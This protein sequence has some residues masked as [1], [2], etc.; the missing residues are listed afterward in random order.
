MEVPLID[1]QMILG[2]YKIISELNTISKNSIYRV[3]KEADESGEIKIMKALPYGTEEEVENFKQ[4]I[5]ILELFQNNPLFVRYEDQFEHIIDVESEEDDG[6]KYKYKKNYMFVIMKDYGQNLE[7]L[8]DRYRTGVEEKVVVEF[9]NQALNALK[10]LENESVVHHDIKLSNFLIASDDPWKFV[11]IDFEFAKKLSDGEKI[12]SR[13]GTPIF[14]A[15]EVL[16]EE[17]H[18]NSAD[19]WGIGVSAFRLATGVYPFKITH[20]DNNDSILEKI[21]NNNAIFLSSRFKNKS[22]ELKELLLKMLNKNQKERITVEKALQSPLFV[23]C[24]LNDN[25]DDDLIVEVRSAL[26]N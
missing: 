9:L 14:S 20:R 12:T 16:K 1:D 8:A 3:T 25:D 19:I 10:V 5:R 21:E 17:P 7:A 18:D 11:L 15:P 26:A 4:E 22:L 6:K 23:N 24:C 13:D 2:E